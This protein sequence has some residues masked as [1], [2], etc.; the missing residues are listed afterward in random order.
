MATHDERPVAVITSDGTT[1]RVD[2]GHAGMSG[3]AMRAAER[4]AIASGTHLWIAA[5]A[6]RV[7]PDA[8]E[9]M[10]DDPLMFDAE[11]LLSVGIGCYVCEQVWEPKLSR[12]RC[13][14][15]PTT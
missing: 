7:S 6:Y 15:E 3:D 1:V 14:G 9:R 5:A 4:Y 12:R 10:V 8:L 13:K 11:N 2:Q